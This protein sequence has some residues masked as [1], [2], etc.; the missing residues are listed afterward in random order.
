MF[1][2]FTVTSSPETGAPR[3]AKLRDVLR[4]K[5]LSGFLVPRADA[6]QGENVAACDE[7]LSWLTGF[8][9][10]AGSCAVLLDIAGVFIDGRYR[11]QVRK[12]VD[13]AAYTPIDWPET[14]VENWLVKNLSEGSIVGYDP[15]LHGF[16]EI[17]KLT[18]A[19]QAAGISLQQTPN[20]VDT[21]W[22]NRPLPPQEKIIAYP[23]EFAG[24]TS[25][26]KRKKIAKILVEKELGATVL[27]LP[28]SIAWLLNIRGND[29]SNTP[30]PLCF[31]I[32]K[33]DATLKLFVDPAKISDD[34][35][36]HLG[37]DIQRHRP[38]DFGQNLREL[39]GKIGVDRKSAPI[40]V[41]EHLQEPVWAKDPCIL[42][43]SRKNPTE[44]A[45]T[46][47]AHLRDAV[48]MAEFLCWLDKTAPKGSLTEIDVV[49]KLENFRRNTNAL[50]DISFETISGSGPNGAIVHY[51]VD[52]NSNRQIMPNDLLLVDSGGQYLD[53]TTDITRTVIIGTPTEDMARCFTLVLKGMIGISMLRWPAGRAG[54]DI[55]AFARVALWQQGLDYDHGTG[56]GV[57][58]YLGVHEG[59]QGISKIND[60]PL[61]P[62]MILSNEPG[63]YRE[64]AWGIRI[65]NLVVVDAASVPVGGDREML[66]FETITWVPIDRRLIVADLLTTPERDWIN[67]YHAEIVHKIGP[68]IKG[69]TAEWLH[70]VCATI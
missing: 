4:A 60:I 10:S 66:G 42:P 41:S 29:V 50:T 59:P 32:L 14:S 37:P 21:I 1:Q 53:G 49:E 63:Y 44:L 34:V 2:T 25:E 12:Q 51:R 56:H 67:D 64:G 24:E 36:T 46:R 16:D 5:S 68:L 19:L 38:K 30:A 27:T 35:I 58:T 43:K 3:L 22:D 17:D 6:H 52:E 28:D 9:G 70:Q 57:G 18:S 45:G 11:L 55:D 61:E 13:L 65:E 23:I 33:A 20:L 26:S 48:A 54:R 40:W 7:R 8:T 47:A 15:M 39:M 31:A 62:G 69:E